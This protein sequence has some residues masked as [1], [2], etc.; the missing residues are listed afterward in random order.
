MQFE[1][2]QSSFGET[3]IYRSRYR[4]RENLRRFFQEFKTSHVLNRIQI[5]LNGYMFGDDS[6]IEIESTG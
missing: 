5:E 1:S 2:T 6:R 4:R 3:S